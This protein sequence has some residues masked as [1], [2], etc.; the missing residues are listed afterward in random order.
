M[1]RRSFTIREAE[2]AALQAAAAAFAEA[3]AT[4]KLLPSAQREDFALVLR[5]A[6][7]LDAAWR[8][9]W[10]PGASVR[11]RARL[12]LRELVGP[13][14]GEHYTAALDD[15]H[16]LLPALCAALAPDAAQGGPMDPLTHYWAKLAMQHWRDAGLP[17]GTGDNSRFPQALEWFASEQRKP[18]RPAAFVGPAPLYR[19]GTSD[20]DA[21]TP[22]AIVPHV[23]RD[24]LR[25]MLG[26][27]P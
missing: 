12:R 1:S 23:T 24:T 17:T 14:H 2:A 4:A 22:A 8:T 11:K 10:Q 16:E 26:K 18:E 25:R 15:L 21:P 9:H 20:S 19:T 5:A 6:R 13:L 27:K 3:V 7:E